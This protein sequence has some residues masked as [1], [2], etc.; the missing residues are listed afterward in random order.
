MVDSAASVRAISGLGAPAVVCATGTGATARAICRYRPKAAV[1]AVT[2]NPRTYRQL[3]LMWGTTP[4]LSESL[5]E[6][7]GRISDLIEEL[8]NRG[9]LAAGQVVPVVAGSSNASLA[10]NVLRVETVQS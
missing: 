1:L 7:P 5:G 8:R 2:D 9:F 10:A 3:N 6:G 4:I